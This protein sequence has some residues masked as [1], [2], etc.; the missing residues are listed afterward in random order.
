MDMLPRHPDTAESTIFVRQVA[1]MAIPVR[2]SMAPMDHMAASD[3]GGLIPG[4][5]G[6]D[7]D[8]TP[9]LARVRSLFATLPPAERL[10]DTIRS[11]FVVIEL[12]VAPKRDDELTL[13]STI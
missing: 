2:R 1:P 9:G 13:N 4:A 12:I 10:A 3:I 6:D 5:G 8:P 11:L 7:A